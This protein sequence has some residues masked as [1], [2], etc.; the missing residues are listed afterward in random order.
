MREEPQKTFSRKF[1]VVHFVLGICSYPYYNQSIHSGV[2]RGTPEA[3]SSRIIS[4]ST[5]TTQS[6]IYKSS[7][8]AQPFQVY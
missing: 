6:Q 2:F 3:D 4:L 1:T 5:R 8:T 7:S